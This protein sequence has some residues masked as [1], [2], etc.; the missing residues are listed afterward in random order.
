MAFHMYRSFAESAV[1]IGLRLLS[2][3]RNLHRRQFASTAPTGFNSQG[4]NVGPLALARMVFYMYRTFAGSTV[5]IGVMVL[6]IG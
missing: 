4:S 3:E 2:M 1:L 5:S 6:S